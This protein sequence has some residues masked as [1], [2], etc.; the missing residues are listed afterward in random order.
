MV[1]D[2][3]FHGCLTLC[4]LANIMGMHGKGTTVPHG[5]Q[6]TANKEGAKPLAQLPQ[7][8]VSPG[9]WGFN[10]CISEKDVL[11]LNLRRSS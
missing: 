2:G 10:T 11:C 3:S 1:S 7:I 6:E 9:D 8:V 4:A 5:G